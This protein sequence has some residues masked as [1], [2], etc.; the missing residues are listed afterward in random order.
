MKRRLAKGGSRMPNEVQSTSEANVG[1][2]NTHAQGV[3]RAT[4]PD[5]PVEP[6]YLI[7]LAG[8]VGQI[9]HCSRLPDYAGQ[10]D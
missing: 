3:W 8:K 2:S 6:D 7:A 9:N 1:F 10:P 5:Y 4:W